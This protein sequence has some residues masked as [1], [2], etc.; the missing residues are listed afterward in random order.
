MIMLGGKHLFDGTRRIRL[1]CRQYEVDGSVGKRNLLSR[2]IAP[3][4]IFLVY[5]GIFV[6]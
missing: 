6:L 1:S 2:C 4:V 3:G 5:A